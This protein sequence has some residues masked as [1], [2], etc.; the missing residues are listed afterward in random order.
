MLIFDFDQTLVDTRAV[1]SLRQARDW[2]TVRV[3]MRTLEPYPGI[4]ELLVKLHALEQ[5]LAI[6]T[7]SPDMMVREF[8]Q[9]HQWPIETVIGYHQMRRRQKPDPYG[10]NLALQACD[11]E[12][13]TSYHV[14]DRAQDTQASRGANV[15]AVGA[16]WGS[17]EID[18]L[19][20]SSPDH[21][22]TSVEELSVFLLERMGNESDVS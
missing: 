2:P 19:I 9:Q 17:E 7:S 21:L 10:L 20:E 3:R 5:P 14:G 12:A 4:T 18:Q 22:F 1:A 6:V 15:I 13:A 11:A 16:G 8:A